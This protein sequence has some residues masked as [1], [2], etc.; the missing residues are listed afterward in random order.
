MTT[1]VKTPPFAFRLERV[2][3]LRERAEQHAEEQLAASLA[4]HRVGAELLDAA[5]RRVADAQDVRRTANGLSGAD[6]LARQ[7]YL[8]RTERA[9]EAAALDL[10]RREADVDARRDALVQAAR[11]HRALQRLKERRREEHAL[12]SERMAGAA[13]DEIALNHHVRSAR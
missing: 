12:Q 8:E 3:A 13:L 2:R 9:K 6:L 4:A 1:S 7:A 10:G 11:D 5:Q